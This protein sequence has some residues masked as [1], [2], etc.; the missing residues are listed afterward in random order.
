MI[1]KDM[2]LMPTESQI[3]TPIPTTS[4]F[5]NFEFF[6]LTF[7]FSPLI[8]SFS[9]TPPAFSPI[10]H[11]LFLTTHQIYDTTP[12]RPQRPI[13]FCPFSLSLITISLHQTLIT[14][15]KP[16]TYVPIRPLYK[17]RECSTNQPFYAK[18]TQFLQKVK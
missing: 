14:I 1:N 5:L 15:G 18:Q 3:K 10:T 13:I 6:I 2:F 11:P 9:H 12:P 16:I 4:G 8:L 17:C 7:Y